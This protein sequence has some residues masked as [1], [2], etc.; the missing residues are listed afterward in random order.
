MKICGTISKKCIEI[1]KNNLNKTEEDLEKIQYGIDVILINIFKL[2]ILFL[3]AYLLGILKYTVI[4]FISFA[5][6]RGF[7]SGVHANSSINCIIMN[8]IIFLGNV[9]LS[10]NFLISKVW[11]MIIF[12]ISIIFVI[13]YAP[14]DTEERPLISK[15][16][17]DALKI[18]AI[19]IV[20]FFSIITLAMKNSIY[21][22]LITYSIFE[23]SILITPIMYRMLGKKYMN[24]KNYESN[25]LVT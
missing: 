22:N 7:A 11:M 3:T 24:Y 4:A 6:L 23:E 10:L 18:K 2:I 8:Y 13:L 12:I 15:K 21:A 19:L 1:I 14:A 20:L 5:I 17:R 16:V 25:K 9:Y